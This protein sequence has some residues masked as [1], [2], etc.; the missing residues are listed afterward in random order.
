MRHR[1]APASIIRRPF[2]IVVA[3][4][5]LSMIDSGT[6]GGVTG[7]PCS[8]SLAGTDRPPTSLSVLSNVSSQGRSFCAGLRL[9]RTI[10]SLLTRNLHTFAQYIFQDF[11]FG[12]VMDKLGVQDFRSA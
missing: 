1:V 10:C 8:R 5:F 4:V 2:N 3:C 6:H 11:R 9:K 12:G 7:L